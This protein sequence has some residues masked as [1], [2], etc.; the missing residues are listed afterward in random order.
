MNEL[1]RR[2]AP[3]VALGLA[4][5]V[6]G[7]TTHRAFAYVGVAFICVGIVRSKRP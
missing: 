3:F 5:V 4:F 1:T 2:A 6:I 7:I